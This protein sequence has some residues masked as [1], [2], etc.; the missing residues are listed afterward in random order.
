MAW[1]RKVNRHVQVLVPKTVGGNTAYVKIVPGVITALGAGELVTVRVG[2]YDT[3]SGT[4]G[5]QYITYTDIDRRTDPNED[6]PATVKYIS[7]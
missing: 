5:S 2:R 7:Y 1:V 4:I 3:D 6:L